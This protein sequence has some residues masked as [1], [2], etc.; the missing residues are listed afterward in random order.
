MKRK[1]TLVGEI[2]EELY[3]HFSESLDRCLSSSSTLPIYVDLISSGG[4]AYIGRAISGRLASLS[5]ESVC[6]V[7]GEASSAASLVLAAC[8]R[9]IVHEDAWILLH[10]DSM[11]FDGNTS[12]IKKLAKQMQAEE[13]QWSRLMSK[14]TGTPIETW[15]MLH[16]KETYLAA[17]D[18]LALGLATE[19]LRS[20]R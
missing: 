12:Q 13:N 9:R 8:K 14:Y 17:H 6:C 3:E 20:K 16:K 5:L 7:Y 18:A 2:N 10:E 1:I 15:A 19:I 4:S 11:E